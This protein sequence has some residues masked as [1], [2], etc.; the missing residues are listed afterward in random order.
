MC[1]YAL[2]MT[3]RLSVLVFITLLMVLAGCAHGPISLTRDGKG[4]GPTYHY[5]LSEI[6]LERKEVRDALTHLEKAIDRDSGAS[7]LWYKKGLLL[8]LQGDLTGAEASV[9]QSLQQSPSDISAMILLGKIQQS[10]QRRS[11]AIET[12][13]KALKS[14]P[15]S[16]FAEEAHLL[17]MENYVAAKNFQAAIQLVE[18]WEKREP[19]ETTPLFYEAWLAQN[20][21][22][23]RARLI[24]AYERILRLEPDNLKAMTSLAEAYVEAKDARKALETLHQLEALMPGDTTI[25]LKM[26][27]IYYDHKQ[28]DEAVRKFE[29]ILKENPESDRIVYYLGVIYENLKRRDEAEA[30]FRRID[31]SSEFFKDARLHLAYLY[32]Q[33]KQGDEAIRILEDSIAKRPGLSAF[34]EYLSEIFRD[35]GEVGHSIDILKKGLARVPVSEREGLYYILGM[36]QDKQGDFDACVASMKKVLRI[37]PKNSGALN[38][39]GYS[40][41]DRGIRLE[42]A[43]D[44]LKKALAVKPDDGYITDSLGW[45]YF[46]K[47]DLENARIFLLKAYQAVPGEATIAEHMGDLSWAEN[48]KAAALRY[49]REA[50]A[51]LMK[52]P[53]KEAS[54][55]RD[56]LRKKLKGSPP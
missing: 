1:Q 56:R 11:D 53:E 42:E 21:L 9:R 35:R 4:R 41:A 29:E 48:E 8:A 25:R 18:S 39:L 36:S 31:P 27:L 10:Q 3:S 43:E 34:Y 16:P 22:Q 17:L 44:L 32:R 14:D 45:V 2:L 12:F 23:D 46:K 24:S 55:D 13:R 50:L 19:N 6:E 26:A 5:I 33:K 54:A 40:F 49:Y 37:N 47:G 28:Y 15:S 30:K 38:Y 51:I 20:F 7:Y 52:K